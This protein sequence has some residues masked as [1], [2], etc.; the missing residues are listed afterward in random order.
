M[1]CARQLHVTLNSLPSL[2]RLLFYVLFNDRA[3]SV[4]FVVWP[5]ASSAARSLGRY[6]VLVIEVKHKF[7]FENYS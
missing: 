7:A 6:V 3:M 2:F 5:F 1:F 4:G